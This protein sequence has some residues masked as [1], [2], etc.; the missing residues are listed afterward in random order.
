MKNMIFI[1]DRMLEAL[2]LNDINLLKEYINTNLKETN[3][4]INTYFNKIEETVQYGT[5]SSNKTINNSE[6]DLFLKKIY[7][8]R[9]HLFK[10]LE[11]SNEYTKLITNL[12]K[13]IEE[14]K[15]ILMT[16]KS[17]DYTNI[18][19]TIIA[20]KIA[21]E[22]VLFRKL[23]NNIKKPDLSKLNSYMSNSADINSSYNPTLANQLLY[24]I[25]NNELGFDKFNSFFDL[26]ISNKSTDKEIKDFIEDVNSKIEALL[27]FYYKF[28][29][30]K[31]SDSVKLKESDEDSFEFN[32]QQS[33]NNIAKIDPNLKDKA[34]NQFDKHVNS[35]KS[36]QDKINKA[37]E[38]REQ[39]EKL[40]NNYLANKEMNK[41]KKENG[42]PTAPY[43]I[44]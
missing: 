24:S 5:F 27:K 15:N 4:I 28:N 23:N 25:N 19:L 8:Y 11:S 29:L 21:L 12:N 44:K 30:N 13:K 33:Q 31:L 10:K 39:S 14:I 37:D 22:Y 26:V 2:E 40:L 34:G 32:K 9:A 35:G 41:I 20:Y 18:A 1:L 16:S 6:Y 36:I 17:I 38:A 43:I 7:T 42:L 3:N